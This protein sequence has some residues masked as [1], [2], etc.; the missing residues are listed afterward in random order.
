M[1]PEAFE[2][3]LDQL[4][5]RLGE[6]IAAQGIFTSSPTFEK[7][8][9]EQLET[10]LQNSGFS[11]NFSPH[12]HVFP[13]IVLP[14]FGI[15]VKFTLNDTWRSVANSVFESTRA[16]DVDHIYLLF[17]KM[18]GEP[19]VR[20]GHYGDCVV[21]VRTSHVPRFEVEIG[22]D[23]SLFGV[24]GIGYSEFS[25]LPEADKMLHIRSYA[26]SRLKAGE[27]LWWLENKEEAEHTLPIQARLY[28]SLNSDDKRC[29][30]AEAALLCPQIV[31]SSRSKRKYDDVSLY[32]LT[33]HGVLAPQVRDL[34][35]AG[36]VA[37]R[38]DSTRG[39]TY[40]QRSLQ[41]IQNEIRNAADYLP[42]ILF[43]EYW[44][45]DIP[46]PQRITWW[47]AEADKYAVDWR[48]SDVLFLS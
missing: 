5:L 30:R 28:T 45:E 11:I 19:S 3:I 24:L 12:P 34:F 7:Q 36:S 2:S 8:A 14:P 26:R 47:L 4:C 33:Y 42:D 48:P 22:S 18:G 31:G 35:S 20:W 29:L 27:R 17:G 39:G 40:I 23:R 46:K 38:A 16:P 10:L 1:N 13:D 43:T 21:H 44:G 6:T 9:R 15:E 41:D 32:L 25:Q 37:L